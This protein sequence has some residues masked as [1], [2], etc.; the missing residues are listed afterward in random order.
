MANARNKQIDT[1]YLSLDTAEERLFTHRDYI[2]HCHRW[3]YVVRWLA[4]GKRYEEARIIDVGCGRELPLAKLLY[5]NRYAPKKGG[6]CGVDFGP[7][8]P[9]ESLQKQAQFELILKPKTDFMNLEQ[10]F[11]EKATLITCFEV[12]EHVEPDHMWNMLQKMKDLLAEDGTVILST[13]NYD[14][15]VGAADNH[16]NEMNH[17][18]LHATLE[19]AGFTVENK[20]GTFASQKDIKE[21]LKQDGLFNLFLSLH[22]YYDSNVLATIFAP[23]Y[24]EKARNCLWVLKKGT[25]VQTPF[26]QDVLGS[27]NSN[28]A[29]QRF[30]T[31]AGK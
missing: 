15:H 7:L 6:Y 17:G 24:P 12:I 2:S 16:V 18:F 10:P 1:T 20:Y 5:S 19:R 8:E 21:L 30:Y 9:S 27:S 29:W 26:P 25:A 22:D 11:A 23:L 28:E 14:P 13:P 3:S 31:L 4:Q